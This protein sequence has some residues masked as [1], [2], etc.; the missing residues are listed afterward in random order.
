MAKLN[1]SSATI[2]L[3]NLKK[4]FR[5]KLGEEA[6]TDDVMTKT[7]EAFRTVK[8]QVVETG[9]HKLIDALCQPQAKVLAPTK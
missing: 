9:N 1:F 8:E 7:R 2:S 6:S 3:N 5:Q 4:R